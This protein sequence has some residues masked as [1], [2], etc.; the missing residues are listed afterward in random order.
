MRRYLLVALLPAG[1][2]AIA[3]ATIV[4]AKRKSASPETAA[5]DSRGQTAAEPSD[6]AGNL[7]RDE[8]QPTE[9][10][11]TKVS[12]EST[13]R[14]LVPALIRLGAI[15]G[16]G[17]VLA[18]EVMAK[19]GPPIIDHGLAIDEPIFHWVQCHQVDWWAAVM[20]RLNKIGNTWTSWGAVGSAAVCLGVS[21]RRQRWLP[22]SAF[23]TAILV[24]YCATHQLHRKLKRLGPPTS[25]LGTY[26]AGG[27]DR[28]VLF[29]GLIAYLLW[30]EFSGTPSGRIWAIGGVSALS[31]ITGYCRQ[32]LNEHWFIDIICGLFYGTML[33][34]PIVKAVQL[35]ADQADL[36]A[37]SVAGPSQRGFPHGLS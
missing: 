1:L 29:Y 35:I 11:A 28:V 15:S 4:A 8:A 14:D 9:T 36:A 32:Y 19:L 23:G 10:T 6:T 18:Y 31:F 3:A 37:R 33:L 22:P 34:M 30:R 5:S 26:P 7:G 16:V 2:T 17:G 25:P 12:C 27:T 21:W 13:M 24:D 20:S